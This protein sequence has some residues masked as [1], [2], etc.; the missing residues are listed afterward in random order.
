MVKFY[1]IKQVEAVGNGY[2]TTL[3]LVINPSVRNGGI[4]ATKVGEWDRK[5]R[6]E[7]YKYVHCEPVEMIVIGNATC[8]ERKMPFSDYNE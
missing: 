1:E 7:E 4:Y 3:A 6:S 8:V 5:F 2:S